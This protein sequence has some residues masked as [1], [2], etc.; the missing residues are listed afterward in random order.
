MSIAYTV[1]GAGFPF[2]RMPG[3]L[4]GLARRESKLAAQF[5]GEVERRFRLIEYD[6]RGHGLS[7]RGIRSFTIADQLADLDAVIGATHPGRVILHATGQQVPA[8]IRYAAEHKDAVAA[9][10]L[11]DPW[12]FGAV[13][14]NT[15]AAIRLAQ[16]N[17]PALLELVLAP[18]ADGPS[19]ELLESQ[20]G[21]ISAADFIVVL[22]DT[23]GRD[24]RP[25]VAGVLAPI[26]LVQAHSTSHTDDER[27]RVAGSLPA[28]RRVQIPGRR[29][30]PVGENLAPFL[31]AM[32]EFL[33][34]RAP[35]TVHHQGHAPLSFVHKS[36][37]PREQ[38][39]LTLVVAGHTNQ[40]VAEALTLSERTVAWH[41]AN[42]YQK[43]GV[44][45][46][47]QAT[48]FAFGA[49]DSLAGVIS[50]RSA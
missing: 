24:P 7:S 40:G 28:A 50:L 3:A 29:P 35:E 31:G 32:D 47:A 38:E 48:A 45:N 27:A 46:R 14:A 34:E 26:L 8:A 49:D 12:P 13:P 44:H 18:D 10:I 30:Y 42:I 43:L 4:V 9:L 37:T 2:V 16:D 22:E 17:F 41:V 11:Y 21:L 6:A 1:T 36:L 25:W 15:P 20:D 33:A 23:A 19:R 5:A 39:V